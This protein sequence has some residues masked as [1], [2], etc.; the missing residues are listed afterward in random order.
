MKDT[1]KE[2]LNELQKL[3]DESDFIEE[4]MKN[5]TSEDF[6][7]FEREQFELDIDFDDFE[8]YLHWAIDNFGVWGCAPLN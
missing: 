1:T 7:E 5:M 4:D 8:E 6:E 3:Y 2:L